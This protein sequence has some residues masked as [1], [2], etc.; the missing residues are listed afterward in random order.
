[1]RYEGRLYRPPSEADAYILQAT[2]GCSWNHCTYCDMYR[3]KRFRI[4][5]LRE[6]LADMETAA[7]VVGDRVGKLFVADGDSLV[8][9][10]D[11]WR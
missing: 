1:M 7:S 11:H 8:L 6:S 10:M 4:R 5:D 2:L 9:P 3:D